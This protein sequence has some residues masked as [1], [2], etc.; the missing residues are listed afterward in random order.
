[1]LTWFVVSIIILSITGNWGNVIF[2]LTFGV[3]YGGVV[4]TQRE[5]I[6]KLL[7]SI[8]RRRYA[9]FLA[10]A[11]TVSVL[12][13]IYVYSLGNK[14][15]VPDLMLDIIIVPAEWAVW[16]TTWYFVISRRFLFSEGEALL[17]A[18]IEGILFEYSGGLAILGNIPGFLVSI[19][20]TVVVYAAIFILPMQLIKFEGKSSRWVKYPI[21]VVLPY[22]FTIPMA[23]LLYAL[24]L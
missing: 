23:L 17:M 24:L 4:Y 7:G 12:E 19:P 5:R 21:A 20:V 22:L 14:I 6:R 11:I 16:F 8:N 10:L 3:V 15:A 13:E 2:S 1:M 18:G 9:L